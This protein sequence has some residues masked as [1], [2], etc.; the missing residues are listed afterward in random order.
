MYSSQFDYYRAK[1][2]AEAGTLLKQH[3]G[4]KLLAGGHTLDPAAEAAAGD[5]AGADRHRPHRAS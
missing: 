5:A 3:P 2:V 1:S 4:A